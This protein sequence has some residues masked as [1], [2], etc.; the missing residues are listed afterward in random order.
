MC[1]GPLV[2]VC[3]ESEDAVSKLRNLIGATNPVD[4]EENTIRRMF[5]KDIESNA[6]HGSDSTVSARREILFFFDEIKI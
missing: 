4:A 3:L 6:I 1:S 5:G 2:V